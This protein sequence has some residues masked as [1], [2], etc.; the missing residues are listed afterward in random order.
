MNDTRP[1]GAKAPFV[2][3]CLYLLFSTLAYGHGLGDRGRQLGEEHMDWRTDQIARVFGS[4]W[5]AEPSQVVALD[6]KQCLEGHSF[7]FDVD[8]RY[9]FDIDEAVQ[10]EVEFYQKSRDLHADIVYE[11]NGQSESTE[12]A[13]IP[14]YR[15]GSHTYT[16]TFVLD[17]A[18]FANRSLFGTDFSIR[19]NWIQHSNDEN[20]EITVCG[21]KL[22]RTYETVLPQRFGRLA[23]EVVDES[24]RPVPARIGIYDATGR[25]PLPSDEAIA[26]KRAEETFHVVN[27][28]PGLI[29]W[30]ASNPSAFYIDR[31]YHAQLP[32]GKYELVVAKGPEYHIE[33]QNFDIED[34]QE[35]SLKIQLRRWDN[36]P[37]KGWYSGDNLTISG[38]IR[39]MTRTC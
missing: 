7:S 36:L 9:A 22:K 30:P 21:V 8:D 12:T 16:K 38:T 34:N 13:Q 10:L 32:V 37:A 1:I 33:R 4:T 17:R 18:R 14:A 28:T 2:A 31:S 35:R 20:P 27:L 25:L 11:R 23:L 5:S 6:G 15:A 39:T 19:L 26:I 29:P 3:A 24:G